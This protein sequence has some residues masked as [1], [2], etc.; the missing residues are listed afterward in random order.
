MK[1]LWK[2]LSC[3]AYLRRGGVGRGGEGGRKEEAMGCRTASDWSGRV[4]SQGSQPLVSLSFLWGQP[5]GKLAAQ[6]L[7]PL[8]IIYLSRQPCVLL[9]N[10]KRSFSLLLFSKLY[11][12]HTAL[13]SAHEQKSISLSLSLFR[14]LY[15]I[16]FTQPF[17]TEYRFSC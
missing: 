15:F 5:L 2:Y 16:S 11:L 4:C 17:V 8:S 10:K 7:L 9:M 14:F 13:C 6:L 12:F 3:R 1:R